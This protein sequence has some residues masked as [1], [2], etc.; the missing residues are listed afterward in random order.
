[1]ALCQNSTSMVYVVIFLQGHVLT[2]HGIFPTAR[3]QILWV[4]LSYAAKAAVPAKS[5]SQPWPT[6][7]LAVFIIVQ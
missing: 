7:Q 3:H 2:P 1:M 4:L 5:P 6:S